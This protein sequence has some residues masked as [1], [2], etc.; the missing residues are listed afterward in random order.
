MKPKPEKLHNGG[1][2]TTARKNSFI[3]SALRRASRRWNPAYAAKSSARTARNTYTCAK[4]S[5]SFGS[6]SVKIDHRLPVRSVIPGE[7][8]WDMIIHRLFCEKEGFQVLC[9]TCH[10]EKSVMENAQRA[11]NKKNK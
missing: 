1:Q 2:W 9:L 3:M 6:K 7:N 4:C 11:S 10:N 8:T 5:K